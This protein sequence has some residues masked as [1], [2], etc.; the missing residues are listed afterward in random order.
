M[1]IGGCMSQKA[2]TRGTVVL[3]AERC[4]GCELCIPACK[5]GVLRMSAKRNSAGYLLPE[6]IEGCTGCSAC[7]LVCPDFCFDI[8]A[9]EANFVAPWEQSTAERAEGKS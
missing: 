8:Y 3:D 4:K 9:L 6:L 1:E 2:L 7:L 5:P